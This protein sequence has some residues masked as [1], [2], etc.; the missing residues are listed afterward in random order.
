MAVSAA[1]FLTRVAAAVYDFVSTRFQTFFRLSPDTPITIRQG[2]CQ[3]SDHFFAAAAVFANLIT[4]FI[5]GFLADALIG[6]VKTVDQGNHDFGITLAIVPVSELVERS[7]TMPGIAGRLRF[8]DQL[9]NLA[10]VCIAAFRLTA[11]FWLAA[12]FR[13]AA[14]WRRLAAIRRREKSSRTGSRQE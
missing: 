10:G 7:P 12:F 2:G 1:T 13:L 5:G 4:D 14:L 11:L 3:G 8:V 6:V 9:G